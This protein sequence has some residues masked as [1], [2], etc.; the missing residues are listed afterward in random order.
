MILKILKEGKSAFWNL[1]GNYK[2]NFKSQSD[3]EFFKNDWFEESTDYVVNQNLG[4]S[5]QLS[6]LT[7]YYPKVIQIDNYFYI[8]N[9]GI[10]DNKLGK[11]ILNYSVD[12]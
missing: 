12:Y 10:I 11:K 7:G 5:I 1:A 2:P 6:T 8:G 4:A 9:F 3:W